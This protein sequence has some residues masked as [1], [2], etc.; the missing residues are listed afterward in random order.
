LISVC[1]DSHSSVNLT[2]VGGGVPD[3]G[4]LWENIWMWCIAFEND[5][6]YFDKKQ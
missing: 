1:E 3:T 4:I 2:P 6:T 5:R